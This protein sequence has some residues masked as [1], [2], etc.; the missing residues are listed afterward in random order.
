MDKVI[1]TA[2]FI[3]ISMILALTLFNVAYPA[4]VQGGEAISGMAYNVSDRMRYQISIIHA[5]S[6][7]DSDGAWQNANGNGQFELY[8]WV[9]NIGSARIIGLD[10]IDVFFGPEGNFRRLPYHAADDGAGFP[11]WTASIAN[12]TDWDPTGTLQI[13]IHY[14]SGTLPARGR[15][16][17]KVTLPNGVSSDYYLGL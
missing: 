14:S 6:E 10:R 16:F 12:D 3:I 9:K 13:T 1:T 7:L 2:L 8:A 4:I 17:I 11:Y 15:Y 5:S